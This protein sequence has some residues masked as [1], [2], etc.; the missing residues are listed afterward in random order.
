MLRRLFAA[1]LLVLL[2]AACGGED[3]ATD[4]ALE[5]TTEATSPAAPSEPAAVDPPAAPTE[6]PVT[7][8]PAAPPAAAPTDVP[9][10]ATDAPAPPAQTQVFE[11]SLN[12]DGTEGG[13]SWGVDADEVFYDVVY[14]E[15]YE[16]VG[17]P[18]TL[19]GPDG[20]VVA[21][22]GEGIR[23]T[24]RLAPDRE[25]ACMTGTVLL[26]DAVEPL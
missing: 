9:A 15:G 21:G 18:V 3:A 13:C 1:A 4:V 11:L 23:V 7:E 2:V 24:G 8:E 10:P 16:V 22:E 17:S 19:V 25:P 26:A 12:G 14:P 20:G 6:S 5:Q